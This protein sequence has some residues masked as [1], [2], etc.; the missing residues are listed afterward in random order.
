MKHLAYAPTY[1]CIRSLFY[2]GSSCLVS[3]QNIL[4]TREFSIR[5]KATFYTLLE[6]YLQL[7]FPSRIQCGPLFSLNSRNGRCFKKLTPFK[8]SDSGRPLLSA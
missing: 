3:S 1:T 6:V 7:P 5:V 4:S 2:R 8:N